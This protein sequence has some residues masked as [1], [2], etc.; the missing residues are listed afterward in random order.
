MDSLFMDPQQPGTSSSTSLN[1]NHS[2]NSLVDLSNLCSNGAKFFE[3]SGDKQRFVEEFQ[4]LQ[5]QN[6]HW[7]AIRLIRERLKLHMR[8]V[9]EQ[10]MR[11]KEVDVKRKIANGMFSVWGFDGLRNR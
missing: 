6:P 2:L 9:D 11:K 1:I 7:S 4:R 8:M 5:L 3:D 10:K